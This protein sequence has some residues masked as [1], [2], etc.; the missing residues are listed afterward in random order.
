[1]ATATRTKRTEFEN[2]TQGLLGAVKINRKGDPEGVPVEPGT[3]VFLTDEEIELTDQSH[4][5][6][7]N[8]PF[9]L[10]EIVHFSPETGDEIARFT[11]A[12]LSKVGK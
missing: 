8:S 4:A 10:R 3:R 2:R 7:E 9:R 11:A 1:M 6:A 12:P 5:K